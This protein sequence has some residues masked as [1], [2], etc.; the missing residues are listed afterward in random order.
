M[1]QAYLDQL[2]PDPGDRLGI[3]VSGNGTVRGH[4]EHLFHSDP[5]PRGPGV[6]AEPCNWGTVEFAARPA[7]TATGS[8]GVIERWP[9]PEGPLTITAWVWPTDLGTD[10]VVLSWQTAAGPCHLAVRDH[11][12]T[13]DHAGRT[14]TLR[15]PIRE[16]EWHFIGICIDPTGHAGTSTTIFA[17]PWGRTGGPF[18][19]PPVDG[20]TAPTPDSTLIVAGQTHDEGPR[21]SF[22][23]RITGLAVHAAA[24]DGV[25]LMF[26]M[27]GDGPDPAGCWDF[28]DRTHPDVV[29][30]IG[31]DV[32]P[33]ELRQGPARSNGAPPPAGASRADR[34]PSGSIHFHRDDVEDCQWP[35]SAEITV[36]D[37]AEAGFY[38]LVLHDEADQRFDAPFV[39]NGSAE[40]TLVAPTLSWQA[41]SNLGRDPGEWPGL[42]HYEH[43]HDG[44]PV[45]IT[46]ARKPSPTFAPS[47][48]LEVDADDAFATGTVATHLLM[49]DLYAHWW[50]NRRGTP[51]VIDD[52]AIHRGGALDG[53]KVLVLSAHPEYWTAAMLDELDAF[54]ARGGNVVYL[55]G[56][57]LYWVTSLHPDKPHVME[58]RRWGG[59]QTCSVE[60]GDRR[61]QFEDRQGGLWRDNG[62][63]SAASVGVE[64]AGFGAGD[65]LSYR[66][67]AAGRS[68]DW[69]W[70]FDGVDDDE[71]GAGGLNTGA[72]NEFDRVPPT[73]EPGVDTTVVATTHMEGRAFFSA[74]EQGAD[75]A[76]DDLIRADIALTRTEAGGLVLALGAITASGCLPTDGGDNPMARICDNV[77]DRMLAAD[78]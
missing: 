39:V 58:V 65:S 42:S 19:A 63:S 29:P 48:R 53:V 44:S 6:I 17:G 66:R 47:A 12:L 41:Y 3:H 76:P 25:D 5:D 77:V 33:L 59:S 50:L 72:G 31:T 71:F 13:L 52:R 10:S 67:T 37:D 24:L 11:R 62:R 7:T 30:G 21:G 26:V 68:P 45:I 64:F 16:R 1:L 46:T 78:D 4:V 27:N 55:G 38:S 8:H 57:G 23:G 15:N 75:V 28:A 36:P 22:D 49:A 18:L 32:G 35:L 60:P 70:V 69:D 51:G 56:N 73:P 43:H 61:H 20:A 74:F 54:L 14:T 9:H 34:M 2:A 40:V